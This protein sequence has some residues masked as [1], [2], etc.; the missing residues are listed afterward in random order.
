MLELAK[1]HLQLAYI[2]SE[3]RRLMN[4]EDE[5]RM[6]IDELIHKLKLQYSSE[7]K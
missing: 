2:H 1:Q 4:K 6:D 5:I 3:K 7:N